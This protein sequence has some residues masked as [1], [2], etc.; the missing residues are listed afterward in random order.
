MTD[1]DV[2]LQWHSPESCWAAVLMRD[3]EPWYLNGAL[4]GFASQAGDA[5]TDLL[6]S[7]THLV[8]F[9]EN[10]LTD[11]Q[12]SLE[13]RVWLFKLLDRGNRVNDIDRMYQAI[14]E[15]NGGKD[16]YDRGSS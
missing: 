12:V 8:E 5:V 1:I 2:K 9:G 6:R 16:P 7:A 10:F 3:G 15:A 4:V 14:R 11:R 13:D